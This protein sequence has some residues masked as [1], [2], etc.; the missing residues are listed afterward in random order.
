MPPASRTAALTI[1]TVSAFATST[2]A[3]PPGLTEEVMGL[4]TRAQTDAAAGRS[5]F[6]PTALVA[7]SGSI[8]ATVRVP[9]FPAFEGSLSASIADR[10]EVVVGAAAAINPYDESGYPAQVL[11]GGAKLQVLRAERAAI[12][13]TGSVYRRPGYTHYNFDESWE[14][15]RLV[16]GEVGGVASLCI[17][18]RCTT[19]ASAHVHYIPEIWGGTQTHGWGGV[20]LVGGEGRHRVVL[21]ATIANTDE[22]DG[23]SALLNYVGYRHAKA[24]LS[25]DAGA[26]VIVSDGEALPWPTFGMS[27]RF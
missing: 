11:T 6:G 13:L 26:L 27:A 9:L 2:F 5:Y 10:L 15:K 21:D 7:P 18:Q 14:E 12:A 8:T 22:E 1:A 17:T 23:H 19:I 3:Q 4:P 16:V 20:S 25:F 24:R